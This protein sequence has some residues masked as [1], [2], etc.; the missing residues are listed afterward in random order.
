MH[1][2]L[3]IFQILYESFKKLID[4]TSQGSQT[5][6]ANKEN[7]SREFDVVV[8]YMKSYVRRKNELEYLSDF[9]FEFQYEG[10]DPSGNV[11][12]VLVCQHCQ[13]SCDGLVRDFFIPVS[14]G[15]LGRAGDIYPI[16]A[17]AAQKNGCWINESLFKSVNVHL[18]LLK[19]LE[20]FN[21]QDPRY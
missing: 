3:N 7:L 9:T 20:E 12:Y 2:N 19:K 4:M 8:K 10:L 18:L 14:K 6:L 15:Q 21:R 1:N 13:D 16:I 17:D 11:M 5:N